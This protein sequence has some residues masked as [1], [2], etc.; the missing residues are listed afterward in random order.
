MSVLRRR[1]LIAGS[2]PSKTSAKGA[3]GW[4]GARPGAGRRAEGEAPRRNTLTA[5]VTDAERAE[6]EAL[7]SAAGLPVGVWVY[8]LIRAAL[9]KPSEP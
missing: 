3:S 9:A 2:K 5:K 8:G 7:A 1:G 4:G 6:V